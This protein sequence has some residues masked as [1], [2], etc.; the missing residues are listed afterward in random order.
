MFCNIIL[1]SYGCCPHQSQSLLTVK[2]YP[3]GE[4]CLCTK[5]SCQDQENAEED[6]DFTTLVD[7]TIAE[8]NSCMSCY[9]IRH[10]HHKLCSITYA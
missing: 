2:K 8:V 7:Q 3:L 9:R 5:E 10:M 4:T 1:K 6:I